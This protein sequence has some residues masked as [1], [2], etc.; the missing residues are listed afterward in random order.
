MTKSSRSTNLLR[1]AAPVAAFVFALTVSSIALIASGKSPVST[2]ADM[3]S[4]GTRL[5][6]LVEMVNRATPLYLSGLAAAIGFK[7]NLF[8]IGVEGQYRLAALVAAWAGAV[9]SLPAP[10]HVAFMLLVAMAVGSGV[11]GGIGVL[12][13]KRGVSEVISSIMLNAVAGISMVAYLLNTHF[14][15]RSP[16]VG[17]DTRTKN[18]PRSAWFPN[19]DALIEGPFRSLR[20]GVHLHGF[21]LVAVAVGVAYYVIVSRTSFG[22]DLSASG[23]NPLAARAAGVPPNRMIMSAMLMSGAVAGLIGLAQIMTYSRNYGGDFITGLGFAGIA[24][25]LL[26]R[27]KP[28]GVAVAAL[29]FGFLER[30]SQNLALKEV[31]KSI[32]AIMQGAILLS[33]VIAYEV[34]DRLIRIREAKATA[35]AVESAPTT[36]GA[37]A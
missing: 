25:A 34:V 24:V 6:S 7:M 30:A 33:V 27:N 1:L 5:E 22:F 4:Y 2:F 17:L 29:L 11:A 28:G 23:M 19:L 14:R 15:D 35:A 20:S 37:A 16:A 32:V 3:L 31:P 13:V 21:V 12:K 8:N 9:V 18:L 10:I 36:L 26:G